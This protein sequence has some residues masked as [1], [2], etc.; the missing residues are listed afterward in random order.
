MKSAPLARRRRLRS[1]AFMK[2]KCR[3]KSVRLRKTIAEDYRG[4][5]VAPSRSECQSRKAPWFALRRL[6]HSNRAERTKNQYQTAAGVVPRHPVRAGKPPANPGVPLHIASSYYCWKYPGICSGIDRKASVPLGNIRRQNGEQRIESADN[7]KPRR[8]DRS[9]SKSPYRTATAGRASFESQRSSRHS[10]RI[11]QFPVV[12]PPDRG[13][14]RPGHHEWNIGAW[15][16]RN[17]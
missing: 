16:Q 10:G 8:A 9:D 5:S 11:Q 13:A 17:Q 2:R 15:P 14:R 12:Q 3:E 7:A 4:K 1:I 6:E